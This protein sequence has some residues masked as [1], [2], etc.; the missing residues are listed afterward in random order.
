M[1]G[2][3]PS[4]RPDLARA[5]LCPADGANFRGLEGKAVYDLWHTR[6]GVLQVNGLGDYV[7]RH[8]GGRR[9]MCRAFR[10]VASAAA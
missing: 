9:A 8:L 6:D 10:P 1:P 5:E 2:S 7:P 4:A 3:A